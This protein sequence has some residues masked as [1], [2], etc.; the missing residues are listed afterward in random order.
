MKKRNWNIF[1]RNLTL[2][3]SYI[4]AIVGFFIGYH[5]P[6]QD[7]NLKVLEEFYRTYATPSLEHLTMP[8]GY[9]ML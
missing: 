7:A 6:I 5:G 8:I 1:F 4:G 3:L 2:I 9:V